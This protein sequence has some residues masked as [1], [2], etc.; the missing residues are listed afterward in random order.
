[1]GRPLRCARPK[2]PCGG[3]TTFVDVFC[4]IGLKFWGL[5]SSFIIHL[6]IK[7]KHRS[8]SNTKISSKHQ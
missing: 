6:K 8:A 2:R 5:D 1:M 4:Y 3:R 7:K